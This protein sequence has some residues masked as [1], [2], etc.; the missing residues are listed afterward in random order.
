MR[1]VPPVGGPAAWSGREIAADGDWHFEL[2]R[3]ETDALLAA[4]RRLSPVRAAGGMQ[5]V[6]ALAPAEVAIPEIGAS[7]VAIREQLVS[8]RALALIRGLPIDH[9]TSEEC[10]LLTW[11]IGVQL[12]IP[13]HQN[14]RRELIVHV[15]DEGK[16]FD[17]REVRA[18]ETA[19]ELN[20]HSDSSDIVGLLCRRPA[21]SGGVSTVVSSVRVHDELV[22]RDPAL[23][24]LLHGDWPHYNPAE[25]RIETRPICVEHGGDLFTHYGR[26]YIELAAGDSLTEEQRAVLDAFDELSRRPDLVLNMDFRPG[27]LQ[28]LNNYKVMHSRTEYVDHPDPGLRR[29]LYRI[30]L[31]VPD[32]EPPP[33][34]VDIGFIPRS[35]AFAERT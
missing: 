29:H 17:H 4:V 35:V 9:L 14:D 26:R 28:L 23:A 18:Y 8:R 3:E 27:D 22:G 34:F 6:A 30:W 32:P 1:T 12:G 2:D 15:R 13:I 20:Y 21:K 19:A 16:D 11:C 25:E 7:M 33:E 10:E 24:A 5:A 31:V